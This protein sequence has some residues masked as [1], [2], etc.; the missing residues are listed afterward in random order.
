ML[1]E[2]DIKKIQQDPF[3]KKITFAGIIV[4]FVSCCSHFRWILRT[5]S[6][7]TEA[8]APCKSRCCLDWFDWSWGAVHDWSRIQSQ[9]PPKDPWAGSAADGLWA[10]AMQAGFKVRPASHGKETHAAQ[11]L[12]TA[13]LRKCSD[14]VL[15]PYTH[16]CLWCLALYHVSWRGRECTGRGDE[17]QFCTSWPVFALPPSNTSDLEFL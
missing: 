12:A 2:N 13:R 10:T 9:R 1:Q 8:S 4:E 3:F 14:L 5:R 7:E 16:K 15:H 11:N 17:N 6:N